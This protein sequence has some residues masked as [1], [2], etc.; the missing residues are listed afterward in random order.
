[1]HFL[2]HVRDNNSPIWADAETAQ[3]ILDD[4]VPEEF[5]G[6]CTLW[7]ESQMNLLYPGDFGSTVENPSNGDIH[8]V[9]PQRPHAAAALC[10]DPPGVCAF[11]ELGDG[12]ALGGQLL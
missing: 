11:L 10:H 4:N 6:L 8:G 1:M 9:L 7:S 5:H 3:K 12:Y 2:L